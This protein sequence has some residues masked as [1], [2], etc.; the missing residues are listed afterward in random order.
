M[1]H[2]REDLREATT[3][4]PRLIEETGRHPRWCGDEDCELCATAHRDANPHCPVCKGAGFAHRIKKIIGTPE[5]D[6]VIPNYA[7]VKA[8]TAEGCHQDT[9]RQGG[10]NTYYEKKGISK[11]QTMDN[12]VPVPGS[13]K[14]FEATN[15]LL[16]DGA[17]P[18]LYIYGDMGCGKTHLCNAIALAL[19]H[20]GKTV[21]LWRM[22]ALLDW[23]REGVGND[24][25]YARTTELKELDALVIDDFES[26]KLIAEKGQW[27]LEKMEEVID[28]RYHARRITMITSNDNYDKL[29]EKILDR[30]KD[31]EVAQM[32]WNEAGNYRGRKKK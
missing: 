1:R 12:F 32:V 18:F 20:N 6:L 25:L 19:S 22:D 17:P 15:A 2:I 16:N 31:K 11:L 24:S 7:Q 4:I 21:K 27:A 29:P 14:P 9:L 5:G 28:S 26:A 10:S 8:C 13:K 23:L 30:F 3:R